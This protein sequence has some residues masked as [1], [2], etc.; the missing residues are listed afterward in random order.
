MENFLI[1]E[2]EK[3]FNLDEVKQSGLIRAKYHSW[4][5]PRN[6]IIVAVSKNIL[7]VLFLPLI[8]TSAQYFK[9]KA[10][11]VAE[12]KWSIIYSND[13]EN[14]LSVEMTFGNE[15]NISEEIPVDEEVTGDNSEW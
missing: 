4:N 2:N 1:D 10:S 5:E 15:E 8:R 11:E 3:I 7:Q 12:G 6:G 14:F 13:F 9:I